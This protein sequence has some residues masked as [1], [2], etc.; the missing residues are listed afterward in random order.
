MTSSIDYT[1][2]EGNYYFY[3]SVFRDE[4]RLPPYEVWLLNDELIPNVFGGS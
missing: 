1:D 4:I 3:I 2:A